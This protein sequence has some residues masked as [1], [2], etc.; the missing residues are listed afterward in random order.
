MTLKREIKDAYLEGGNSI[1]VKTHSNAIYVDENETETLTKRLDDVKSSIAEH[2]TQLNNIVNKVSVRRLKPA[3]GTSVFWADISA[4]GDT[5][6]PTDEQIINEI[7]SIEEMQVDTIIGSVHIGYK[8][9]NLFLAENLSHLLPIVKTNLKNVKMTALKIHITRISK[10]TRTGMG[11]TFKTQ[12]KNLVS[13]ILDNFSMFDTIKYVYHLNE[14]DWMYKDAD[15][16]QF[17]SELNT[18]V[19]SRGYKA[20]ITNAGFYNIK[21]TPDVVYNSIDVIGINHYPALSFSGKEI[22]KEEA[23]N[24]WRNDNALGFCKELKKQFPNM[25]ITITESGVM[26][27]W[28]AL[29]RPSY[30][31]WTT[32]QK[33]ATGGKAP[34][35][36][37]WGLLNSLND[38]V[39]SNIWWLFDLNYPNETNNTINYFL[40]GGELNNDNI[41]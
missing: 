3:F 8:D 26:D 40:R 7:K 38:D 5:H 25:E 39:V 31:S 2:T 21:F 6:I 35:V 16:H 20:G 17:I 4:N 19:R 18:I 28:I 29:S 12:Y 22:T 24:A 41:K 11:E 14:M 34:N 13:T 37:L 23:L 33:I 27:Y 15:Y 10:S 30:Y 1:Y 9:G 36:Y 32:E